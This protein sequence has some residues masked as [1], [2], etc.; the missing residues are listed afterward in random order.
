MLRSFRHLFIVMC[1]AACSF[2]Y[3]TEQPTYQLREEIRLFCSA[4]A[5]AELDGKLFDL[6]L[7]NHEQF[8]QALEARNYSAIKETILWH[9]R[10]Q[11]GDHLWFATPEECPQYHAI[12]NTLLEKAYDGHVPPGVQ[13]FL[14]IYPSL[15][16]A[17]IS[18]V[19]DG[20]CLIVI[21]SDIALH[22]NDEEATALLAHEVAHGLQNHFYQKALFRIKVGLIIVPI[23]VAALVYKF[24]HTPPEKHEQIKASAQQIL[25][26]IV[27]VAPLLWLWKSRQHEYEADRI[28][29]QLTSPTALKSAL[30]KLNSYVPEHIDTY[31]RR[32][33]NSPYTIERL[34]AHIGH[35]F[36]KLLRTHPATP[37]RIQ[38]LEAM[39]AY[40]C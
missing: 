12:I 40:D 31:F 3:A 27:Q 19:V 20:V 8:T 28:G 23:V 14:F 25:K 39:L 30:N 29:A 10:G 5:Q 36:Y 26:N 21:G 2:V 37:D 17:A 38:A 33:K 11:F 4:L 16:N 6:R 24:T 15:Y 32:A 13:P 7:A 9:L 22:L 34:I 35:P 18:K 1:W